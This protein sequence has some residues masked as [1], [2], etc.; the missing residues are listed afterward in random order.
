[1]IS[2][3]MVSLL[4]KSTIVS[5]NWSTTVR[6]STQHLNARASLMAAAGPADDA[7]MTARKQPLINF[8][9][10]AIG[11]RIHYFLVEL[12]ASD[13]AGHE[14]LQAVRIFD[15]Q[16]LDLQHETL[17]RLHTSLSFL[18]TISRAKSRRC[19]PI[20][21]YYT[22]TLLQHTVLRMIWLFSGVNELLVSRRYRNAF[23]VALVQRSSACVVRIFSLRNLFNDRQ[24]STLQYYIE[25]EGSVRLP[26]KRNS[27][28]CL[29]FTLLGAIKQRAYLVAYF[30]PLGHIFAHAG[31]CNMLAYYGWAYWTTQK[32]QRARVA[33]H[34]THGVMRK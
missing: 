34:L 21:V 5:Q 4:L 2:K 30:D 15:P 18:P 1:M 22:Y 12:W 20:W 13:D 19:L 27:S 17:G 25:G 6:L 31:I 10:D 7:M 14:V 24:E 11:P 3:V 16:M 32:I 29:E 23:M 9:I 33:W 26:N 8:G 28:I